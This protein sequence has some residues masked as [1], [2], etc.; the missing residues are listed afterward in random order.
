MLGRERLQ[1]SGGFQGQVA[2]LPLSTVPQG[3]SGEIWS[4]SRSWDLSTR[5]ELLRGSSDPGLASLQGGCTG[6]RQDELS[7]T[8]PVSTSPES[9]VGPGPWFSHLQN[10]TIW[11]L[12]SFPRPLCGVMGPGAC[13]CDGH[14]Q[15]CR[16]A[17]GALIAT[18][19]PHGF[20]SEAG[21]GL[22]EGTS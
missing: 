12:L 17:S 3:C 21:T 1:E 19:S 8:D 6:L 4:P 11:A 13:A 22:P 18:P 9:L 15:V 20:V 16:E 10:G 2:C 14:S 5:R 7:N